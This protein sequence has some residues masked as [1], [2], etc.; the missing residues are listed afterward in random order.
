MKCGFCNE[1]ISTEEGQRPIIERVSVE[2]PREWR[3]QA[4][5]YSCP[6][7]GAVF[8]IKDPP[9]EPGDASAR[10]YSM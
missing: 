9:A 5:V 1:L 4:F 6:H 10:S 7:C 2:G 8:S 3:H